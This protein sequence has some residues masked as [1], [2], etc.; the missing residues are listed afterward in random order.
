MDEL[1]EQGYVEVRLGA[2]QPARA[3][4][5]VRE[6]IESVTDEFY[7]HQWPDLDSATVAWLHDAL[8]RLIAALP[9]SPG[10]Q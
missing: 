2:L 10:A 9:A 4:Y 5:N 1:T 6:E 3:G 8:T 7:F